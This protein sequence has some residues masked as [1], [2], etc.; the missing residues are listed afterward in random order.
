MELELILEIC[1]PTVG[2]AIK[3]FVFPLKLVVTKGGYNACLTYEEVAYKVV[4]AF[5]VL[6]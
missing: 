4:A 2:E 3:R 1:T 6:Q 5:T